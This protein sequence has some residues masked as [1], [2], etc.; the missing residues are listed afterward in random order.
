M[1]AHRCKIASVHRFQGNWSVETLCGGARHDKVD[2]D[3]LCALG[4]T[5]AAS[6][7]A[8]AG[9]AL[10][11]L[12]PKTELRVEISA[13]AEETAA[14]ARLEATVRRKAAWILRGPKPATRMLSLHA[15]L[16]PLRQACS[17]GVILTGLAAAA[18]KRTAPA[19]EDDD[20]SP[21]ALVAD[22]RANA[23]LNTRAGRAASEHAR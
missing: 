8:G 23:S 20:G 14:Y 12:P 5:A 7:L 16:A 9:P 22:P 10:L 3:R 4:S 11:A 17:G 1:V 6:A 21:V 13:A 15:L 2:A 18:K 19:E